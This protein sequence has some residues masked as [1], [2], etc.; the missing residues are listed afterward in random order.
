MINSARCSTRMLPVCAVGSGAKAWMFVRKAK[1][2][3][4]ARPWFFLCM[5]LGAVFVYSYSASFRTQEFLEDRVF[6]AF[7]SP[8][9]A[10]Y[11]RFS[12]FVTA[13]LAE[14]DHIFV[15]TSSPCKFESLPRD[16]LHKSSCVSAENFDRVYSSTWKLPDSHHFRIG[17]VHRLF[18]RFAERNN[19]QNIAVIEADAFSYTNTTID[20]NE[21]AN[22]RIFMR[23]AS[24]DIIRF[25]YRPYF[26]ETTRGTCPAQCVCHSDMKLRMGR[27]MC[28]INSRSC[29]IRSSDMYV[30]SSRV[31]QEFR[32]NLER[33]IVDMEAMQSLRLVWYM[34]PQESF[35]SSSSQLLDTQLHY[36]TLFRELCQK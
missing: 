36:A 21:L 6:S 33:D 23:S 32:D 17:N 5:S 11:S 31:F 2:W 34:T 25:G 14:V 24:W 27:R 30:L 35:Q 19:F 29:D 28:L 20:D 4:R 26:L 7:E 16:W 3:R 12:Q 13:T 9:F 10:E 8:Q 15:L 1:K 18:T 22:F